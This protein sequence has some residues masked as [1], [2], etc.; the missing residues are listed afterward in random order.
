MGHYK[1]NNK[2]ASINR[3]WLYTN[4]LILLIAVGGWVY[5]VKRPE[6]KVS[7]V[8]MTSFTVSKSNDHY[9]FDAYCDTEFTD[10]TMNRVNLG[11]I[12]LTG[13]QAQDTNYQTDKCD[14]SK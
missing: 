10:G 8:L 1:L 11:R 12:T 7:N 2:K 14:T 5:L 3:V 9:T 4:L 6:R 13:D